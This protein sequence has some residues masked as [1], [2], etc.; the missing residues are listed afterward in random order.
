MARSRQQWREE[1]GVEGPPMGRPV[2]G[3]LVAQALE[4]WARML[5]RQRGEFLAAIGASRGEGHDGQDS[6]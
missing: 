1:H 2:G 4:L 6:E 3:S 5:P